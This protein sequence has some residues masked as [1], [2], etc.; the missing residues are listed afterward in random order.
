[1][2]KLFLLC[3]LVC[4]TIPMFSQVFLGA[5]EI[6]IYNEYTGFSKTRRYHQDTLTGDTIRLMVYNNDPNDRYVIRSFRFKNDTCVS[7]SS[8]E[9]T[10]DDLFVQTWFYNCD[11]EIASSFNNYKFFKNKTKPEDYA[12]DHK[13]GVPIIT[14][15]LTNTISDVSPINQNPSNCVGP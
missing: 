7:Y 12:M 5:K 15:S 6:E 4:L 2:K 10:E 13:T 3:L 11:N 1:M 9:K 14:P 8:I